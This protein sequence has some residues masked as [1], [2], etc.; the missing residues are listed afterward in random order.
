MKFLYTLSFLLGADNWRL[1]SL[2]IEIT[3]VLKD[4][5]K[6]TTQVL[7]LGCGVGKESV[8]LATQGWKVTGIDFIPMAIRRAR[9]AAAKA[10]VTDLAK[11]IQRMSAIYPLSICCRSSSLMI[12]AVFICWNP[13]NGKDTLPGLMAY[14]KVGDYFCCM[15]LTLGSKE[16]KRWAWSQMPLEN[17]LVRHL[18]WRWCQITVIG[19][20]QR[21]GIGSVK[22]IG[23]VRA[24]EE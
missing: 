6:E 24:S 14:W 5:N 12:L 3:E 19:V 8:A 20:F 18:R 15:P 22:L 4:F 13:T 11:F 10:G 21:I 23:R 9:K 17:F 7:D 16:R 2:P 1:E